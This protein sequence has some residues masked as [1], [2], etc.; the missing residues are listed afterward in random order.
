[1]MESRKLIAGNGYTESTFLQKNNY[2]YFSILKWSAKKFTTYNS[3]EDIVF[4]LSKPITFHKRNYLILML[5]NRLHFQRFYNSKTNN[6]NETSCLDLTTQV[7]VL[8]PPAN[9]Q[10]YK[11]T[12]Q[13]HP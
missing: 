10:T 6:V 2:N 11:Q 12:N 13:L 1:M 3:N 5:S 9:H 4:S 7:K 8:M